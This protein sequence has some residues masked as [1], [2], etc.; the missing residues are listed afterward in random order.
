MK[1]VFVSV[2]LNIHQV[3]ISDELYKLTKG[4][5]CF[6]ETGDTYGD[7]NKGGTKRDYSERPYLIRIN[8]GEKSVQKALQ[9]IREADVMIYGASP[10][11][12]L[13]ER[14]KT[15]KLTFLY[16]ERWFKRGLINLLSKNLIKQQWFYHTQCHGKPLYALCASA[17]AVDDF[18]KMCSFKGK[19][20]KWGYFTVVDELDVEALQ[21]QK[22]NLD[23]IR[24]LWIGRLIGWKHPE[25]MIELALKLVQEKV[26]FCINMIGV[27]VMYDY[28]NS[29]ILEKGLNNHVKLLGTMPNRQVKEVMLS[30][31]I[32]CLTSDKNEGWGAVLNEAM[33]SGCCPVSSIATG[34]TPYLIKYGIN[35]LSF[36]LKKKNDLFEKVM[37]LINHSKERE[38]MSIE[39]YK[40]MRDLWNPR[41]AAEQLFK[42]CEAMLKGEVCVVADGP[43]SIA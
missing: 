4:H 28:L 23:K 41:N 10:L 40:T 19:C 31:H 32:A 18:A 43:C 22:R 17:Y 29:Q 8:A 37:W 13:K 14:I 24:I 16:S 26:D 7:N 27:G 9:F 1:I 33:S 21:C 6:V 12:F 25:T 3:G 20:F 2:V 11:E 36:D 35:G 30:H 42:L 39:A 34:S 38:R 5:F 15:G